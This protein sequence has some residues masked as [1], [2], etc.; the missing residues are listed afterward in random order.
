ME[1]NKKDFLGKEQK[2][3]MMFNCTRK[4]FASCGGIVSC[5]KHHKENLIRLFGS[6]DIA[7][8]YGHKI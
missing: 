6:L 3:C 4:A 7:G 5:R 2:Q 1:S 8:K